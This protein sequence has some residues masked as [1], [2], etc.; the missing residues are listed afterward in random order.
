MNQNYYLNNNTIYWTMSPW[1]FVR[2]DAFV[3]D[4]SG[5]G[6]VDNDASRR[7][8]VGVRAAV[9]LSSYVE[10]TSGDGTLANPYVVR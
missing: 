6:S 2:F 8:E 9:N 10:I 7:Y 3:G 5:D 4:V 1:G